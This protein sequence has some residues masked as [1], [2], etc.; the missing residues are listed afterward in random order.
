MGG[1]DGFMGKGLIFPINLWN[2]EI[3]SFGWDY[4]FATDIE[5]LYKYQ[6]LLT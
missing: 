2:G 5:E 1:L 6:T 4:L 3:L